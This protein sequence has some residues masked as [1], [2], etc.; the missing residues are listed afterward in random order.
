MLEKLYALAVERRRHEVEIPLAIR[1][2][3][4]LMPEVSVETVV[5]ILEPV[6]VLRTKKLKVV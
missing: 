1:K 6:F 5:E 2:P 4:E 3:T